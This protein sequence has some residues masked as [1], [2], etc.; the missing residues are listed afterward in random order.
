MAGIV[1]EILME[2]GNG[3]EN[4]IVDYPMTWCISGGQK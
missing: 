4:D 3:N 1:G 2:V